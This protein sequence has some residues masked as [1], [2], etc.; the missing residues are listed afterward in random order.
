M[1]KQKAADGIVII[2]KYA[3]RRLYNTES[4]SYITLD[5]LATM[6][7]EGRDFKVVDAKTDEDITHNVLTQIIME[8]ESRGETMMP[9]N[10]LRQL[11]SMYG[12]SMQTMVPGYLEASMDSFR[13]N[14]DQFKSAVEGAF[15]NSPFADIAKRN[16]EMFDAATQAMTPPAPAPAPAASKDDEIAALRNE[17]AKLQEKVEK[18]G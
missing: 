12:D 3:N 7:R 14:H 8:E 17:L 1:K 9:V 16:L 6:T 11:I 13:R 10:F 18:L 4:S 15:A 5:H 2:K